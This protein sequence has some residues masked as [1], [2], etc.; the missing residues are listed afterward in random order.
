MSTPPNQNPTSIHIK[1]IYSYA[2][3][4]Q[5]K[6]YNI[7]EGVT[8]LKQA[9]PSLLLSL[10]SSHPPITLSWEYECG[11]AVTYWSVSLTSEL[12]LGAKGKRT[13]TQQRTGRQ[14][15]RRTCYWRRVS[16]PSIAPTSTG[17]TPPPPLIPPLSSPSP[18][19]VFSVVRGVTV[20]YPPIKKVL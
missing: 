5:G 9:P 12:L 6:E 17:Y 2:V 14:V 8:I 1:A 19:H 15:G 11:R 7:K 18:P 4:C 13:N 16:P 20:T 10:P 3:M